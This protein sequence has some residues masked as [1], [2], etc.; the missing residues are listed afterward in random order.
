MRRSIVATQRPTGSWCVCGPKLKSASRRVKDNADSV[1]RRCSEV[2]T[3][4]AKPGRP[5]R[6][7]EQ[8]SRAIV[9]LSPRPNAIAFLSLQARRFW[10]W[11]PRR[12]VAARRAGTR[13]ARAA[14][15]PTR[16]PGLAARKLRRL[17]AKLGWALSQMQHSLRGDGAPPPPARASLRLGVGR[18]AS[19][20]C[21]ERWGL[22]PWARVPAAGRRAAPVRARSKAICGRCPPVRRARVRL[23]V[24]LVCARSES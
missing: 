8:G 15:S 17:L 18:S 21:L 10:N 22:G 2:G 24:R 20:G 7:F 12:G 11:G 6:C 13:N 4:R 16:R 1:N 19:P 9:L 23:A 3:D 14:P 5:R